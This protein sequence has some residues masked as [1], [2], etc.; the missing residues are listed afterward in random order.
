MHI[1]IE[2]KTIR[3]NLRKFISQLIK[4]EAKREKMGAA[5]MEGEYPALLHRATGH[6]YFIDPHKQQEQFDPSIYK[7]LFVA[8]SYDPDAECLEAIA[9]EIDGKD[10]A[11]ELHALSPTAIHAIQETIHRINELSSRL[12][13]S[14]SDI[15]TKVQDLCKL[16]IEESE[17]KNVLTSAWHSVDRLGAER[18]LEGHQIGTYLLRED[19]FAKLLGER[20]SQELDKSIKCITLSVL[21]AGNKISEF[22][23]VHVDHEWR[24]YD[25]VLFCN[26]K[27]FTDLD[28]LIQECFGERARFV[29]AP[30]G[31]Q[32]QR[33]LA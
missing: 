19:S 8:Y 18:L 25:N 32:K 24:C 5:W 13:G 31:T 21:D 6:L 28:K 7:I 20:L 16:Q 14:S 33:R 15:I 9:Y 29:L 10:R 22:T 17:A 23:L 4:A 1:I 3:E 27:G 12:R 30:E 26:V 11:F 2:D